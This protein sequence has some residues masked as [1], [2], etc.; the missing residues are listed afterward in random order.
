M[1]EKNEDVSRYFHLIFILHFKSY[2]MT[3]RN[4]CLYI[5]DKISHSL[6]GGRV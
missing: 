2:V 6:N 4:E 3:F 1:K 5:N